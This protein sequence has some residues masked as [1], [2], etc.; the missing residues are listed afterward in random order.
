MC[1]LSA[2][3]LPAFDVEL[4]AAVPGTLTYSTLPD[5][6]HDDFLATTV[7]TR[8]THLALPHFVGMPPS[9]APRLAVLD[10]T[11]GC[12]RSRP[13]ANT[14]YDGFRPATLF[15]AV[16]GA[17]KVLI[18]ALAPD[19][20]VAHARAVVRRARK[21]RRGLEL[22]EL[23]HQMRSRCN[24]GRLAV[25]ERARS[26]HTP[27]AAHAG[28]RGCQGGRRRRVRVSPYGYPHSPFVLIPARSLL[29]ILA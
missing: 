19:V 16:V 12:A 7:R 4:L 22:L 2:L 26:L 10:N 25:F 29:E 13:V 28:D 15:C 20:D 23:S 21:Y 6:F 17:L 18:L 8:L 1:T 5:A 3:T 9:G 24:R 27:P 11:P 14:V